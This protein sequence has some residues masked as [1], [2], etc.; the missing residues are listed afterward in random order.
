[1]THKFWKMLD[2]VANTR[3]YLQT[4]ERRNCTYIENMDVKLENGKTIKISEGKID[5]WIEYVNQQHISDIYFIGGFKDIYDTVEKQYHPDWKIYCISQKKQNTRIFELRT[6]LKG[7]MMGWEEILEERGKVPRVI[8]NKSWKDTSDD[9]RRELIRHMEYEV[10]K[11]P[12]YDS[13]FRNSIRILDGDYTRK[14]IDTAV[15]EN[16][17]ILPPT[18]SEKAQR[19]MDT[20]KATQ[21]FHGMGNWGDGEA[22][23]EMIEELYKQYMLAAL[24]AINEGDK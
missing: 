8:L 23:K 19:I 4:G 7:Y 3:Y 14:E 1:M 18:Y 6:Y 13:L 24:W 21:A 5:E 12:Q 9:F 20:L 11:Y 10:K 15:R 17:V 16:S 22:P 2:I